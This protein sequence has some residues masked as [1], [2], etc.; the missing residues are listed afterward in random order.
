MKIPEWFI[1]SWQYM[2]PV[3]LATKQY[4]YFYGV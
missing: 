4:I 2:G 3:V 1:T